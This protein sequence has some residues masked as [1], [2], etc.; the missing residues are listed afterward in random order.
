MTVGLAYPM[1]N[2]IMGVRSL[3]EGR[4]FVVCMDGVWKSTFVLIQEEFPWV[5]CFV[6]PVHPIDV[7]LKNVGS[8]TESIRT[9][10][11]VMGDVPVSEMEWN[12]TFFRD[13][14]DIVSKMV[15]PS[16]NPKMTLTKFMRHVTPRVSVYFFFILSSTRFYILSSHF[17]LYLI[18]RTSADR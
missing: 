11:N 16:L 7:F 9:Q 8:S 17:F 18:F 1:V 2:I 4:V 13:C 6:C 14:C 15:T 10:V 3:G 5:W 12:E